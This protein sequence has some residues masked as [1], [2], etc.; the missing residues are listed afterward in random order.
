MGI[1][2]RELRVRFSMMAVKSSWM[3]FGKP[4]G[5]YGDRELRHGI[6]GGDDETSL[7]LHFRPDLVDMTRPRISSRTSP[8]EQ[9]FELLRQTGTHAFAWIA[10]TLRMPVPFSPPRG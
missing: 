1:V 6:H 7:M 10:M 9:D 2:A 5:L 3:R 4:E 8:A